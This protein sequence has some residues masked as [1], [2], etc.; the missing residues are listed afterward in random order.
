MRPKSR[1]CSH[2]RYSQGDE[3]RSFSVSA[4]FSQLRVQVVI[5]VETKDPLHS[6]KCLA[7]PLVPGA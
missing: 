6:G 2:L 3:S 5:K 7:E 4:F 1:P